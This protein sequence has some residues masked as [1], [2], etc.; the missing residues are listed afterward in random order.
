MRF[1][2]EVRVS[3]EFEE[4]GSDKYKFWSNWILVLLI[5]GFVIMGGILY[6]VVYGVYCISVFG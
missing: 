6:R 2:V 4:Y 3:W 5:V 1:E